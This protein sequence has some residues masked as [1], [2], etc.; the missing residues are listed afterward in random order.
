MITITCFQGCLINK[1]VLNWWNI[2]YL[3]GLQI[4][5]Q[6]LPGLSF[7]THPYINKE[8]FNSQQIVGAKDP[9]RPF[10]SGQN[11][12]PLVKWRIQELDES[13]LPLSGMFQL[14]TII[15]LLANLDLYNLFLPLA[16]NC[17]PSVSGNETYVNIEYEA[18]EMFDL[19][20]VAI[21]IPLPALRE[22]PSVRQIDGEWK[23]VSK[24]LCSCFKY[25][26]NVYVSRITCTTQIMLRAV[27]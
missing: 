16:V 5:N 25:S 18:S 22:A 8:L 13:S 11:E 7:K 10:P 15:T 9:N 3:H 17:C 14:F 12:T 20:N 21:S 27:S 2:L 23:Y 19:H 6:D 24:L 4:E 1:V 26:G